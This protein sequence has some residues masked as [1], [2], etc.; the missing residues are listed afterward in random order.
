MDVYIGPVSHN[1][2]AKVSMSTCYALSLSLSLSLWTCDYKYLHDFFW[3]LPLPFLDATFLFLGSHFLFLKPHIFL[4]FSWTVSSSVQQGRKTCLGGTY[5]E[6]NFVSDVSFLS[7]FLGQ[8]GLYR[9]CGFTHTLEPCPQ[10]TSR[11]D[12]NWS[13]IVSSSRCNSRDES[14]PMVRCPL[15]SLGRGILRDRKPFFQRTIDTIRSV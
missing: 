12:E 4:L 3:T 13:K 8:L 11:H 7:N 14:K 10:I 1:K 6:S 15:A 9:L 2:G 5:W